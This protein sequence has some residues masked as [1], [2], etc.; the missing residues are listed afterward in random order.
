MHQNIH[1]HTHKEYIYTQQYINYMHI[2][3]ILVTIDYQND[4]KH[5]AGG[6]G[7]KC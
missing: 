1:K 2:D 6:Q 7:K 5:D 3:Y 4:I